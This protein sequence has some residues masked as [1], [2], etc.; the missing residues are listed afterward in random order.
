V[1]KRDESPKHDESAERRR[2]VKI[3]DFRAY[4]ERGE[5]FAVVAAYDFLYAHIIDEAGVPLIPVGDSFGMFALGYESLMPVTLDE[6]V[7]HVRAVTKGV[8]YGIVV[9]DLPFGTYEDGPRQALASSIRLI[10]EAGAD[11][12]KVEGG[13][14]VLIET[15]ELLTSSGI[16]VMGHLGFLPQSTTALGGFGVVGRDEASVLQM[17]TDAK[18]Q[19]EA[20]AFAIV[21]ER[22]PAEA[23]R[24]VTEA[25]EVPTIG[26]GAGAH[27]DAQVMLLPWLLG[28][29]SQELPEWFRMPRWAKRYA[30]QRA[31]T[32]DAIAAF[33][34]DVADGSFPGP[35]NVYS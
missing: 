13:G 27:T 8:T 30:N 17:I 11:A 1:P 7:H 24:R 29:T 4:K 9:A 2:P 28:L 21:L 12:V 34:R 10:K 6:M 16:P 14:A 23:G 18:A 19:Q 26:A 25:V 35:D 5:P 33:R 20:G 32:L 3:G 22:L 31:E 15:I